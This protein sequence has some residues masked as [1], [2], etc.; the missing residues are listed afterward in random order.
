MNAFMPHS[1]LIHNSWI[2]NFKIEN[3]FSHKSEDIFSSTSTSSIID[4]D[5]NISLINASLVVIFFLFQS[6]KFQKLFLIFGVWINNQNVHRDVCLFL[7]CSLLRDSLIVLF[8]MQILSQQIFFFEVQLQATVLWHLQRMHFNIRVQWLLNIQ[9]KL[10]GY[11][12]A[13]LGQPILP[14]TVTE[15]LPRGAKGDTSQLDMENLLLSKSKT[16]LSNCRFY[17]H[18]VINNINY[19]MSP[20]AKEQ[21]KGS[22]E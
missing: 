1:H 22:F 4:E 9:T 7:I 8:P 5:H 14:L 16:E 6:A 15:Y 17:H 3:I 11:N 12:A 2:Q 19:S 10:G 21:V 20:G 13:A 18:K